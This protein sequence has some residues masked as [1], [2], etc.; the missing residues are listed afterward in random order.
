M[1][2]FT[3][4]LKNEKVT[5]IKVYDRSERSF[6]SIMTN[7][8]A[9][10]IPKMQTPKKHIGP[11]DGI[12]LLSHSSLAQLPFHEKKHLVELVQRLAAMEEKTLAYQ[13]REAALQKQ[14]DALKTE[15]ASLADGQTEKAQLEIKR[16]LFLFFCRAQ[17]GSKCLCRTSQKT[18]ACP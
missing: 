13:Q 9:W 8:H 1:V 16:T 2:C 3:L 5:F 6:T 18:A 4:L 11:K 17:H 12:D 14:V 15:H 7:A 10:T